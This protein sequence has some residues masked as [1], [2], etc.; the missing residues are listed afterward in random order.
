MIDALQEDSNKQTNEI[1]MSI[2]KLDEKV[3]NMD[4]KLHKEIKIFKNGNII[5][6]KLNKV[7]MMMKNRRRKRRKNREEEVVKEIEELK[8]TNTEDQAEE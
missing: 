1:R 7:N 3:S 4:K 2:Q 6:K 5:I 8:I